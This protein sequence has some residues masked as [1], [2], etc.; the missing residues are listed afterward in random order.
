ME[1]VGITIDKLEAF[2]CA[3]GV[4]FHVEKPFYSKLGELKCDSFIGGKFPL[5]Y[6]LQPLIYNLTKHQIERRLQMVLRHR[7]AKVLRDALD[8]L[9]ASK[10][11]YSSA[12]KE[13][14]IN[15]LVNIEYW[16]A[17]QTSRLSS[18]ISSISAA[19]AAVFAPS[20]SMKPAIKHRV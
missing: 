10:W 15:F 11:I 17:P 20:K 16:H 9:A 5:K 7:P 19:P 12:K 1:N 3:S 2:S 6:Y 8:L 14:T 13:W 18:S 4:E